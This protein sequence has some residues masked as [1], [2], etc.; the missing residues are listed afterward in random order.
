MCHERYLLAYRAILGMHMIALLFEMGIVAVTLASLMS[1]LRHPDLAGSIDAVKRRNNQIV[2]TVVSLGATVFTFA[3]TMLG[4]GDAIKG[5][6]SLGR[7]IS[8]G[9]NVVLTRLSVAGG[10]GRM[11]T[12]IQPMNELSS[13]D[14]QF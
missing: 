1:G 2:A 6:K 10:G 3:L 11:Q 5:L 7:R 8:E 4:A 9:G 13:T 14:K 12:R